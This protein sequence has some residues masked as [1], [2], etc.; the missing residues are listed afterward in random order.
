MEVIK[1][2]ISKIFELM[3]FDKF[4]LDVDSNKR[5]IYLSVDDALLTPQRLPNLVLN[6]NRIS[7][8]IAKKQGEAP[9]VV[10]INNYRKERERLIVEL[11]KAAARRAVATKELVPLPPMN[12]Y[13][14][15][16]IHTELS[17]RPDV[18]T[19]SVGV[20]KNRYVVV[21]IIS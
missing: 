9:I 8:L 21:K 12:A 16:L 11:A 6:I 17:M 5:A 14:R 7:R 10:D 13:E 2:Q 18:A 4:Q 15:R 1:Q 3:G 19:E 20:G